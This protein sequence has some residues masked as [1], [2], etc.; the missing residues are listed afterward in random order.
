L[1]HS[2][3]DVAAGLLVCPLRGRA[4]SGLHRPR[5][6]RVAAHWMWSWMLRS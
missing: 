3:D 6:R 4:A 5:G 1:H 2:I